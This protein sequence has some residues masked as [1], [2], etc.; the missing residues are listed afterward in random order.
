MILGGIPYYLGYLTKNN[1][2]AQNI[3][4]LFFSQK[5]K[6]HNE[7]DR[8]FASVFKNPEV[9]KKIIKLLATRHSGFTR[10][11]LISK[12]ELTEGGD[13]LIS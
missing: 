5:P 4:Q 11:E 13:N 10:K 6:L 9:M 2:L 12:L 3:D 1:S 8:L 7:F